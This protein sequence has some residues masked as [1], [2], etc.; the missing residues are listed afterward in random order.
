MQLQRSKFGDISHFQCLLSNENGYSWTARLRCRFELFKLKGAHLHSQYQYSGIIWS[1]GWWMYFYSDHVVP[2]R[3]QWIRL[4]GQGELILDQHRSYSEKLYKC[5]PWHLWTVL[6]KKQ[7]LGIVFMG[8]CCHT[9]QPYPVFPQG[10]N[11]RSHQ[12][13]C[14]QPILWGM[15]K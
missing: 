15:L 11:N 3:Q 13:K 5:R 12:A 2:F 10:W 4:Y 9:G 7:V 6:S 1:W 8:A 14:T